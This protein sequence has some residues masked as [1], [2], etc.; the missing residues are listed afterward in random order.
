MTLIP[1]I[2]SAPAHALT[3]Q[4]HSQSEFRLPLDEKQMPASLAGQALRFAARSDA[5]NPANLGQSR[6]S[7]QLGKPVR[8]IARLVYGLVV[9]LLCGLAGIF[10]HAGAASVYAIKA[11]LTKD[12]DRKSYFKEMASGH[13]HALGKDGLVVSSFGLWA[14]PGKYGAFSAIT[15]ASN[16]Q[17]IAAFVSCYFNDK[18]VSDPN[19]KGDD[20]CDFRPSHE[21]Y[22][23]RELAE[24]NRRF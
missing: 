23:Y 11:T 3:Q 1:S 5:L 20:C 15:F 16:S 2:V 13:A 21:T 8:F 7:Q 9:P 6:V 4:S 14:P 19:P 17:D 10:Y 18:T 12:Q 22:V 24:R